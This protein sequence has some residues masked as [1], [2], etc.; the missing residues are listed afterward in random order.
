MYIYISHTHK[1]TL[2]ATVS[3][4]PE[5]PKHVGYIYI[6]VRVYINIYVYI[7]TYCCKYMAWLIY[8]KYLYITY[9]PA[10]LQCGSKLGEKMFFICDFSFFN[11]TVHFKLTLIRIIHFKQI[12]WD[13]NS[14]C[15]PLCQYLV[16]NLPFIQ[17]QCCCCCRS[18]KLF[19]VRN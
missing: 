7:Y 9:I 5:G 12:F 6:Y 11:Q 4:R 13:S 10:L 18:V 19:W 8:W 1:G 15:R 16:S 17:D 3:P 2:W 14:Q